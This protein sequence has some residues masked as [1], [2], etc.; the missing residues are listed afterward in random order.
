METDQTYSAFLDRKRHFGCETGFDPTWMPGLLF[1][2]QVA[3]T[4]WALRKGRAAIFADCGLG[5]TF[6]QLV[7]AENVLRHTGRPVLIL[8][9]LAVGFQTCAEG[10]KIGLEVHR[11][12][13]GL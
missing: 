5:K 8:A 1:P 3:L 11:R 7:W 10:C 4:E 12:Q 9:P 13:D 2:F 6:M